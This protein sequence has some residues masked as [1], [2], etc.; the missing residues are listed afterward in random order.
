MADVMGSLEVAHIEK[1]VRLKELELN[2]VRMKLRRAQLEDEL[3][4]LE[5]NYIATEKAI[6]ELRKELS[7][8][9]R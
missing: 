3:K 9:G 6:S 1:E 5:E 4:R 7:D 2:I 8:N